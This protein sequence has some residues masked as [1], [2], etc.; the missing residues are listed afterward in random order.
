MDRPLDRDGHVVE[1]IVEDVHT[2]PKE[3]NARPKLLTSVSV[4]HPYKFLPTFF[5]LGFLCAIVTF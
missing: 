2:R 3:V 5:I 1:Y 4:H